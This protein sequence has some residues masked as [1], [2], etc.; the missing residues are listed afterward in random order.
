MDLKAFEKAPLSHRMADVPVPQLAEWFSEGQPQVWKV[1]NLTGAE[2]GWVNENQSR[3]E[4]IA[5][6]AKAMAGEGDKGEALRDFMALDSKA[7]PKAT[8]RQI[9]LLCLGSVEP[10]LGENKRG[11]AVKLAE[12]FPGTFLMLVNKINE[13]TGLGSEMGKPPRSGKTPASGSV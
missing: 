12:H 2:L 3:A 5:A 4:D 6:L 8:S 11:I 7:V 1:R 10:A 13:L 9:D